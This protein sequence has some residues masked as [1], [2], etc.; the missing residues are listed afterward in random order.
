MT[1]K[2]ITTQEGMMAFPG[3]PIVLVCVKDNI[4]IVAAVSFFSFGGK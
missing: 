2:K 1:K 3:F 4:I